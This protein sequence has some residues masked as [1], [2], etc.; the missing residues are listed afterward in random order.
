MSIRS[1]AVCTLVAA[2]ALVTGV[3]A[4]AQ[5][6][7]K[8]ETDAVALARKTLSA[9]LT[10]PPD[11]ISTISVSPAQWRDSS[12]GCPERGLRYLPLL[13][14]GYEVKLRD[15]AREHV[16]HVAGTRAVVCGSQPDPKQPPTSLVA[17]T[18]K[19]ADAVRIALA[20]RLGIEPARVRI[21]STRPFRSTTPCLAAPAAS[22]GGALLVEA[23]AAEQTF[24][25]YADDTQVLNCER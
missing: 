11:Q 3:T 19:A 2:A 15:A 9:A 8:A 6:R 1:L 25:Y 14:S 20:A 18:L 23:A 13:T 17:G 22:K 5:E 16:V 7:S 12:L 21:L 10:I 4:A 24:R